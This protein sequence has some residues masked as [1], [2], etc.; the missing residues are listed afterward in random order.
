MLSLYLYRLIA[1]DWHR[2]DYPTVIA[3]IT[4]DFTN[5]AR[6]V[7]A[8][9]FS[10]ELFDHTLKFRRRLGHVPLLLW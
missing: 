7:H 10:T 3:A 1:T 4:F 8:D 9:E 6:Q 2:T 5:F